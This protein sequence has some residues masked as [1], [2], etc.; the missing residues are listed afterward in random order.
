MNKIFRLTKLCKESG[1]S[2]QQKVR[3][4]TNVA[5]EYHETQHM[6]HKSMEVL[7]SLGVADVSN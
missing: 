7:A 2:I 5:T 3:G 1:R 4:C 6:I